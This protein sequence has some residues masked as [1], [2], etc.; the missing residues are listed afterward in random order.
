MKPPTQRDLQAETRKNQLLDIALTLFAQR[1]VENVSIKD[2]AT[3]ANVAQGLIYHYFK[4]KDDLLVAI[5]Q[6][7]N[8]L[9]EFEAII[10]QLSDLPAREGLPMFAQRLAVLLPEKRLVIRLL[11]RE[12]LSPR[13]GL[14]THVL[15]FREGVITL[16][17]AYLQ[18]RIAVGELKP[19]QPLITIHML[20]SSLLTLLLLEQPLEPFVPQLVETILDGIQAI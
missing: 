10:E 19:H 18:R 13:S 5:F 2:L 9:P 20:A 17:T 8:P 16:M 4:S 7:Y 15:S 6:R 11:V 3:E 14:L 1:G 12:L